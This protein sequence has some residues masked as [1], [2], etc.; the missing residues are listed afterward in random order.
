MHLII[1]EKRRHAAKSTNRFHNLIIHNV[2]M[3]VAQQFICVLNITQ[4]H[5]QHYDWLID[6]AFKVLLA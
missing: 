6:G 1:I 4:R 5:M 2:R 3:S